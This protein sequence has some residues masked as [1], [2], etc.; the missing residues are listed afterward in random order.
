MN[1]LFVA[2]R[3][4]PNYTDSL[5]ALAKKNE[6]KVLVAFQI[7]NE[8]HENLSVSPFPDGRFSRLLTIFHRRA[9][10]SSE[11]IAYRK[12]HPSLLWLIHFICK[13]RINVIYARR[14][15]KHL[16]RTAW[17]AT[18]VTNCRFVSFRQQ[19]YDPAKSMDMNAIYPLKSFTSFNAM[20]LN[21]IPLSID[22][23]RIPYTRPQSM[24]A[25]E[26]GEPLR[27]MAVGK[28]IERKGHHL[29]IE[30]VARLRNRVSLVVNIYGAYSDFHNKDYEHKIS[31]L[32]TKYDLQN[33]IKLMPMIEPEKMVHEY[34]QHDLFVYSGWVSH[35][36][37]LDE[38][39]YIRANGYCGTRLYSLIEAM[40]CGLPVVCASEKHVVGAVDNGGSGLVFEK[41]DVADLAEKIEAIAKM[42]LT[43]M[44]ARSRELIEEN[45]DSDDFP[46]RF[47]KF[48]RVK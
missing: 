40:A 30:A 19:I 6:L 34:L 47:Q 16:L 10:L 32:I 28:L 23:G 45:F 21:F 41:K 39:T 15:N 48:M 5:C 9:G 2:P 11:Q 44:G 42:D 38:D 24:S 35:E 12:R 1:I 31:E 46:E 14:D 18:R 17:L 13:N 43:K 25:R 7:D 3:L 27:I 37:D 8:R 26:K 20:P 33:C 29:L 36:R 4:H 22:L